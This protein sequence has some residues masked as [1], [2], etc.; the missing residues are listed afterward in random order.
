MHGVKVDHHTSGGWT[1]MVQS[2]P[3]SLDAV[4]SY[5]NVLQPMPGRDIRKIGDHSIWILAERQCRSDGF[6]QFDID[7]DF[8][9]VGGDPHVADLVAVRAVEKGVQRNMLSRRNIH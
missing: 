2:N 6:R 9:A 1:G 8:V 7:G 5:R 4:S 3:D